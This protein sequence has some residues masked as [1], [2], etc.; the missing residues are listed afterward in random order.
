MLQTS[1]RKVCHGFAGVSGRVAVLWQAV[2][3]C[4]IL[5]SSCYSAVCQYYSADGLIIFYARFWQQWF[6]WIWR[7]YCKETR[8]LTLQSTWVEFCLL[9]KCKIAHVAVVRMLFVLYFKISLLSGILF[10]DW[11]KSIFPMLFWECNYFI[12]NLPRFICANA[13]GFFLVY[14]ILLVTRL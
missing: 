12:I 9:C 4:L 1:D 10:G 6:T 3:F 13:L 14:K 2:W 11:V 8:E 7:G 5:Y